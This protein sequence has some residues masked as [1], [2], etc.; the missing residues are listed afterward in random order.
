MKK[1]I[2]SKFGL[3]TSEYV[4]SHA[5]NL[6]YFAVSSLLAAPCYIWIVD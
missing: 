5:Y 3:P 6:A 2:Y 1:A 4:P